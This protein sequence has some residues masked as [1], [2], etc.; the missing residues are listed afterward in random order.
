MSRVMIYL[1]KV[2]VWLP[3]SLLAHKALS[4]TVDKIYF[5]GPVSLATLH[6]CLSNYRGFL[7]G[8]RS[9]IRSRLLTYMV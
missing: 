7:N 2:A 5:L 3:C 9:N 4:Y 6:I 8:S 1:P